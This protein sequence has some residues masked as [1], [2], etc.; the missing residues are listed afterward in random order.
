MFWI[1]NMP[2][3]LIKMSSFSVFYVIHD[4]TINCDNSN[5]NNNN[6]NNNKNNNNKNDNNNNNN[7]RSRKV[8]FVS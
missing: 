6:N 4:E 3:Q 1:L 8:C 7:N 5:S 2:L